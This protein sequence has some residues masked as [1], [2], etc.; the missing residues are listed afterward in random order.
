MK[1]NGVST[2]GTKQ[3]TNLSDFSSNSDGAKG[4]KNGILYFGNLNGSYVE[5]TK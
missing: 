3:V 2:N 4:S 1:A 5:I